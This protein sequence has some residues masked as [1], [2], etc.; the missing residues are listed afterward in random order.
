LIEAIKEDISTLRFKEYDNINS[1]IQVRINYS[2][3]TKKKNGEKVTDKSMWWERQE[4]YN[5][6]TS[7]KNTIALLNEWGISGGLDIA[8][9]IKSITINKLA[10]DMLNDVEM[11]DMVTLNKEHI[12]LSKI[13]DEQKIQELI[14][15]ID[16]NIENH[17]DTNTQYLFN[18][19][20]NDGTYT[21]IYVKSGEVPPYV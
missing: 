10:D 1:A 13:T 21:D 9:E 20:F 7:Y 16:N 14:K 3:P 11:F 4:T 8:D 6:R 2:T 15:Y 5:I 19:E 12:E 17:D 18:I